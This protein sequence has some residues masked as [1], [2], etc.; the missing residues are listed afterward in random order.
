MIK[1]LIASC[2]VIAVLFW[3]CDKAE[4][5]FNTEYPCN[6]IFRADYHP[7]SILKR[8]LD[9]PGM[10]VYVTAQKRQGI[11]HLLVY[12]NNGDASENEDIALTTEIENRYNYDNIGANQSIIIGCS[13]TSE[14]H[15]YDRQ[16]PYCLENST[17]VNFPLTWVDNGLSVYCAK[18]KRTYNLTYGSSTDGY[19]LLEYRVRYDGTTLTVRNN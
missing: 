8:V 9:N 2:F 16:C 11:I 12:P 15:A 7:T 18:C 19:R 6:F 1:R 3:G 5:R 4:N 17:S 13:T 14:W 10:F